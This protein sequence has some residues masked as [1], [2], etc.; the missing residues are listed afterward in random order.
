[1]AGSR[2]FI[3]IE[4]CE[5]HMTLFDAYLV[6]D[7]SAKSSRSPK[8]PSRDAIWVGDR[9]VADDVCGATYFRTRRTCEEHLRD[10]LL[11]LTAAGRRVF[12]G[13][14]FPY[15]Y[16]TGF[17]AAIGLDGDAPPWR[18]GWNEL[19]RLI[20]DNEV[21]ANNRFAVASA[22]NLRCHGV[23]LGPFWG[24]HD[25]IQEAALDQYAPAYPYPVGAGH[26]LERKRQTED[27]LGGVQ[28]TWQLWGNGSVGSQTL[29]GI[30]VVARLRDDPRL[31]SISRVWPF[32]TG[33]G[34]EP[35]AQE[36]P[37]VLHAEIWPGVI[38]STVSDSMPIKDQAQVCAMVDW[39]AKLDA[40]NELSPLFG[41]PEELSDE[42]LKKVLDEEGWIFGS[43][44]KPMATTS[45]AA[46]RGMWELSS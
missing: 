43:G 13:F 45:D 41:R 44:L 35:I 8:R 42:S 4:E 14:D 34:L 30:P 16:P 15:G 7:W 19:T 3:A 11:E 1:L 31:K 24:C 18:L 36:T 46:K 29:V 27:R 5:T 32:E 9:V 33:F 6:V 26:L 2:A 37:F 25:G 38:K 23:E 17:A 40:E 12:I 39:L 10:R 28:P 20:E 22:L 21:N